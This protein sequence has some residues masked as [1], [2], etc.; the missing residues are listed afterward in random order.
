[1]KT[2]VYS[3]ALTLSNLTSHDKS[4]FF[5]LPY[6]RILPNASFF[7]MEKP[8]NPCKFAQNSC[9]FAQNPCKFTQN[10][11]KFTQNPC[12]FA[13]NPCKFTQNPCKFAQ[14]HRKCYEI[15]ILNISRDLFI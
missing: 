2:L 3:F 6:R 7:K 13:Q 1:M 4:Q 12:K 9:K 14:N 11:C 15:A 10:P 8:Y 5:S